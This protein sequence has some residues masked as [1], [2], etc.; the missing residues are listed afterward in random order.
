MKNFFKLFGII[1]IVAVIGFSMAACGGGG[2]GNGNSNGNGN[3]NGS[4]TDPTITTASLPNGTVGTAYSQTLAA[5]GETPITWSIDSRAK[6]KLKKGTAASF[7]IG[8]KRKLG[9]SYS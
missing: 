8:R 3:G 6:K 2:N 7:Y 5:T 4:G 1:A 9:L